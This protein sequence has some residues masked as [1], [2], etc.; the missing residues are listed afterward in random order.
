[1]VPS[2]MPEIDFATQPE[3][4]W[5]QFMLPPRPDDGFGADDTV[6]PHQPSSPPP[7][8]DT[9]EGSSDYSSSADDVNPPPPE[10]EI[11]E[12]ETN[13]LPSNASSPPAAPLPSS[14]SPEAVPSSSSP[15]RGQFSIRMPPRESR[16]ETPRVARS[17][18][19]T[20]DT[21]E[22]ARLSPDARRMLKNWERDVEEIE[23]LKEEKKVEVSPQHVEQEEDHTVP[24]SKGTSPSLSAS[25]SPPSSPSSRT[26]PPPRHL[27]SHTAVD[28]QV[29][30]AK[31]LNGRLLA[32]EDDEDDGDFQPPMVSKPKVE[33]AEARAR[34][35]AL[36]SLPPPQPPPAPPARQEHEGRVLVPPT[37]SQTQSVPPRS[38]SA[39]AEQK[40]SVKLVRSSS[41]EPTTLH[42][43][44]SSQITNVSSS[45]V[46]EKTGNNSS[47][48]IEPFTSPEQARQAGSKRMMSEG[49]APEQSSLTI[50]QQGEMLHEMAMKKRKREWELA[51]SNDDGGEGKG[52]KVKR[53]LD[54]I[55]EE[56]EME[57]ERSG[58]VVAPV[59]GPVQSKPGGTSG[60]GLLAWLNP[61]KGKE[62][63]TST[64]GEV[65]V[66]DVSVPDAVT[67]EPEPEPEASQP[68]DPQ[69]ASAMEV[70]TPPS[71]HPREPSPP[72]PSL[73]DELTIGSS[74]AFSK[75]AVPT[76][77]V[78]TSFTLEALRDELAA[79]TRSNADLTTQVDLFRST[80]Q[81]ASSLVTTLTTERNALQE[82]L[83]IA[84]SQ[85]TSG[86]ALL[87]AS[88]ESQLSSLEKDRNEW[89]DQ[90]M[91]IAR[92]S[93]RA[94][95]WGLREKAAEY[96]VLKAKVEK[97]V[98]E[99]RELE[100]E[101]L[102]EKV[103]E[104]GRVGTGVG[105]VHPT[106][107]MPP[108]DV[109]GVPAAVT[110]PED[111]GVQPGV[112]SH[113]C[114]WRLDGVACAQTFDSADAAEQHWRD[115]HLV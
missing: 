11:K 6:E 22:L 18:G 101:E 67:E 66:P 85:A 100:G 35:S 50:R 5:S 9:E 112:V 113:V 65:D 68:P 61:W 2:S 87:R 28:P 99:K 48:E 69:P 7:Q 81:Q 8:E 12:E 13:I 106:E 96:D 108:E 45:P 41:K 54:Q 47:S 60:G 80:Y 52:K 33:R 114:K 90:A 77:D 97:L 1:M 102:R 83:S 107:V 46:K 16:F 17:E 82:D 30:A 21:D 72:V 110:Q 94:E 51:S 58:D 98:K 70:D 42:I 91:L 43:P 15:S 75:P 103:K 79:L 44:S 62:R 38:Q 95:E 29:L 78:G 31:V 74:N 23:R 34:L 26:S 27:T 57:R 89:R 24:P 32:S 25:P 63:A 109:E 115:V 76:D 14:P 39:P 40:I 92:M 53:T 59:D 3:P 4:A 19:R 10:P 20:Q 55:R 73:A 49:A 88:F 37:Q 93:Q 111:L 71:E 86:V 36:T 104:N 64:E 84:K 105:F 56:R